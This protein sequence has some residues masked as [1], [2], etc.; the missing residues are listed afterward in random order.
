[1][2][3]QGESLRVDL[4]KLGEG[5]RREKDGLTA[6]SSV[7]HGSRLT[8]PVTTHPPSVRQS[9]GSSH[10]LSFRHD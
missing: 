7:D 5:C 2:S 10:Q 4:R 3:E 9:P 8:T 1:M 6:Q